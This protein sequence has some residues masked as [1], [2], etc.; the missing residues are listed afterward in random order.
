MFGITRL[1]KE[2]QKVRSDVRM[3]AQ[4][5]QDIVDCTKAVAELRKKQIALQ[6]EL[7]G[8]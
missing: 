2:E 5:K 6:E 8:L 4:V 3:K 7:K 1:T